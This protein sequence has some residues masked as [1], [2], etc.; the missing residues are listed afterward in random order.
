MSMKRAYIVG[1]FRADSAWDIEQNV[2][3]AEEVALEAWRAGFA[4]L[5]PHTNTRFF[6]G[7]APDAIW[8]NGD[9][10]WLVCSHLVITVDGWAQSEGSRKEVRLATECEIPVFASVQDAVAW[11]DAGQHTPPPPSESAIPGESSEA[12]RTSGTSD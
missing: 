9:L 11:R 6:Q 3:R 1:P 12:D 5:C 7:A 8:L 4:V 10:H 2:R